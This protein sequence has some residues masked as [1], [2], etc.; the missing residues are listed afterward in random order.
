MDMESLKATN[1]RRWSEAKLLR[2]F[3]SVARR[4]IAAKSHYQAV[5][6]HTGVPWPFIAVVHEREASQAW[7]RQLAQGDPLNRP[8]IHVPAG[9][10][11]FSTWEAGAFDALVHCAPFAALNKDWS[12]GSLLAK[13]E[14]YNG[15]GYAEGPTTHF[16]DG[17]IRKYQPTA[18]PYIWAGTD[19]YVS[20]K[21]VRDGVYD[22][23]FVDRQLG[24]AGL[25]KAMMELDNS[26]EFDGL[27]SP[28]LNPMYP[29]PN[30]KQIPDPQPKQ[31][32]NLVDWLISLFVSLFKGK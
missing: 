18:S 16:A 23:N 1:A 27:T 8:S 17:T 28:P 25:L 5:S 24:C 3:N 11:P 14:E 29:R 20:G 26:I 15:L 22:P 10:G 30:A 12:I 13:L 6:N 19:Q 21:Y 7:D 2:D 32:F 31:P 9:R 4:L